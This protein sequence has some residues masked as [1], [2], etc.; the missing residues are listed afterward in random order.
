VRLDE[1]GFVTGVLYGNGG[2]WVCVKGVV[3]FVR[4]FEADNVQLFVSLFLCLSC[5]C[6]CWNSFLFLHRNICV[7]LSLQ[8]FSCKKIRKRIVNTLINSISK[9]NEDKMACQRANICLETKF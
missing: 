1:A 8:E 4:E 9:S 7:T 5:S 2:N 3:D 6:S